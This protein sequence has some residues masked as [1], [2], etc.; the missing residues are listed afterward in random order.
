MEFR[1]R[2]PREDVNVSPTHPL[3]EAATL[4]VGVAVVIVLAVTL[5]AWTVDLLVTWIPP[6]TEARVFGQLGAEMAGAR[7]AAH[8]ERVET[9]QG[10]LD[11]LAARWTDCPYPSFRV[12]VFESEVVELA[13][14]FGEVVETVEVEC[15]DV[16]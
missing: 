3:R 4:V 6:E 1:P 7:P 15:F 12:E 8:D 14:G 13:S 16:G 11:R 2:V 5:L 9:A 10:I